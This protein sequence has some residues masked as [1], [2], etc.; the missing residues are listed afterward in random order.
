[1]F[2]LFRVVLP[3]LAFLALFPLYT[4]YKAQAGPVP[5]G[6]YLA[7]LELS[8]VKDP[9]AIREALELRYREPIAVYYGRERLILLPEEVGFQ[10]DVEAMLQEAGRYLQGPDFV[11]IALRHLLGLEQRRRDVPLRYRYDESRLRAWLEEV[12]AEYD[13]GPQPAHARPPQWEWQDTGQVDTAPV[14]YTGIYREDWRWTPGA[15]GQTLDLEASIPVVLAGLASPDNRSARLVVEETPPPPPRMADLA[16]VLDTYT[17]DFPG[18]AAIYVQDLVTGEE[19]T[20]DVDVAFSGMSTMKVA[21]IAALFS[22]M[23]GVENP[24]V[25]QW[26]DYALGESSNFAANLLL[27][28]LGDGDIYTGA[29][30]VTQF[31][32]QLGYTNSFIQTGYDAKT[33]LPPI[34]TPANQRTDWNTNPDAHLQ[35]TPGEM[36]RL[37]AEIYRCTQG[38]GALIRTF[39]EAIQPE[40]CRTLLFY[41][42]HNEFQ[43]LI[44][45]GIPRRDQVWIVHKHGFV[46]EAHSDLAL[47]QGP[48]GPYVLA[49]YLWR[50][51][52]MDWATSNSTMK[53]ISRIVWRYFEMVAQIQ[54]R[55]PG[56]PLVLEPPP[57]YVPL[58]EEYTG[59]AANY[60]GD[61]RPE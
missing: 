18:F 20:V 25:G 30:R 35:S 31:M 10:I 53:A 3:I 4:R 28:Y 16:A 37:L 39:Q 1:M 41:M 59:L 24:D 43:E 45:G 48:A 2:R 7:G 23:D 34:P 54:G 58:K 44:W 47:V 15:P 29:R 13:R 26:M 8:Q 36:G 33:P 21:I 49:V 6:V 9:T 60:R 57:N 12:A 11:D 50:P 40:E 27:R 17:S 42:S 14:G 32:R 5:P 22:R 55:E 51:G 46:N 19:A 38:Q 56:T 52:W 61:G